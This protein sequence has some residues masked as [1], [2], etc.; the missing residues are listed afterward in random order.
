MP[1]HF[2][3]V[4]DP[5]T[6]EAYIETSIMGKALLTL[7]QLNKGTA[8]TPEERQEFQ[9]LG[10]L[11]YRVESIEEQI[12][13]AHLQYMN[14]SDNLHKNIY[15]QA[16]HEN[17]QTL[18]Y[19]LLDRYLE[20]MLPIVYTPTVADAVQTYSH[21][22]RRP[23]GLYISY[24]DRHLIP[25]ILRH[26]TNPEIDI[27]VTSDAEGVL[28]IGDQGIGGM[29]IPVAK[30]MV[31]TL[32]AGLNPTRH[33]PI[34]LDV[35]TN[36]QALLDDPMYLGWRHERLSGEA[37]DEMI[38][39][40]V[41]AVKKEFPKVFLHWEDFGRDNARRNLERFQDELCTFNDDM[42]GTAAVTLSAVMSGAMAADL[43][44]KDQRIVIFGAGTAGVGIAGTPA[45]HSLTA[46]VP[47]TRVGMAS[48]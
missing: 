9:L 6:N 43:D 5:K 38:G 8:F 13:R 41:E 1:K 7:P 12:E 27:I 28:G 39:L 3:Y 20:E 18:F 35:G 30:L 48:G 36:N 19:A 24:P 45:S 22:Y 10:K 26:R 4:K 46:S 31:Y 15:L 37:Y 32:C 25:E 42:Q 17:N 16:L 2:R 34:F 40:F 23:R 47:V 14:F 33:L 44:F 21:E 11:P 29:C